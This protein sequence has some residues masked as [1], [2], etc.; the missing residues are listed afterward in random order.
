M[1]TTFAEAK[2]K[3]GP[4]MFSWADHV[5]LY[6]IWAHNGFDI[7]KLAGWL[8]YQTT[9]VSNAINR[10]RPLLHQYLTHFWTS[11]RRRPRPVPFSSLSHIGLLMDS[12]SV[13]VFRPTGCFEEAKKYWDGKNK[14]YALK[15]EVAV[16]ASAPHFCFFVSKGV[17]ASIHD[18]TLH[19]M[20]FASYISYLLK[21]PAEQLLLLDDDRN[22]SF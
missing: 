10:I 22:Q 19:L 16:M 3:G 21:T 15:V 9:T 14:N 17:P 18:Y 20:N 1:G 4:L 7:D 6:L 13:E 12:T 11:S 8:R 2:R 5:V